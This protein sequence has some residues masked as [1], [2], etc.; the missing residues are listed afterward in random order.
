MRYRGRNRGEEETHVSFTPHRFGA[1]RMIASMTAE[2]M[3]CP[4]ALA[5]KL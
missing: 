2:D 4:A 3:S 5:G 1:R